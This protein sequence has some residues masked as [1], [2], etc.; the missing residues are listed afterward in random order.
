MNYNVCEKEKKKS[1][2][3]KK[4]KKKAQ[5]KEMKQLLT[6]FQFRIVFEKYIV[7]FTVFQH[8]LDAA[9]YIVKFFDTPKHRRN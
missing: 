4:K 5:P 7:N 1:R 6:G 3:V 9:L 2:T 8:Y